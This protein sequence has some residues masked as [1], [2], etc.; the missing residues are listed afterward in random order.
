MQLFEKLLS[1]ICQRNHT[2]SATRSAY[3]RIRVVSVLFFF[4]FFVPQLVVSISL[5]LCVPIPV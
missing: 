1:L 4:I 3:E 5:T 2:Q